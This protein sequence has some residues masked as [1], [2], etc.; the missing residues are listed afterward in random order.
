MLNGEQRPFPEQSTMC[1]EASNSEHRV[2]RVPITLLIT[3][4]SPMRPLVGFLWPSSGWTGFS[5]V[6]FLGSARQTIGAVGVR[7]RR[8]PEEAGMGEMLPSG[9]QKA[10]YWN[11]GNSWNI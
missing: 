9:G 5:R 7:L 6:P 1:T 11:P 8:G 4:P 2:K 3:S 10:T